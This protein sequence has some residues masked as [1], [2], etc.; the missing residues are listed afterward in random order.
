MCRTRSASFR[1]H[2]LKST[3]F[4]TKFWKQCPPECNHGDMMPGESFAWIIARLS[5][6]SSSIDTESSLN[7]KLAGVDVI[8]D[9]RL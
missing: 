8:P 6:F 2:H 7:L 1:F 5:M 3:T 9:L 4:Q